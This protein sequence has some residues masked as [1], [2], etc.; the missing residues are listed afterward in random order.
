MK[1]V[2][3][4][5]LPGSGKSTVFD[6]LMQGAG[7]S[8][9]G[10]HGRESV[11]V[12]RVPDPRVDRL[13]AMY[14]PK[15][16]VYTQIQFVDTVATVSGSTKA[17]RG[18]DLFSSVRNCDALA[19]VVANYDPASDPVRDLRAIETE[20]LLADLAVIETRRERIEKEL[21]VGKRQNEREHALVLRCQEALEAER[22]LRGETFDAVEEK[23]LRGFQLLTLKPLLAID[24]Q[25][26]SASGLPAAEGPGRQV[27]SLKALLEREV[28]AL[29]PAE[30]DGFRAELGIAEDGLSIVIRA[31]YRL[32]GLRSFFTVGED[33]VR[34]WTVRGGDKAVDA[35]GEIHSDLAKGFIR[36]E[37]VLWDKLIEA[38][39]EAKARERAWMRLEGR[40]YEVQ[41]GDCL[42][43][44]FNK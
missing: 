34:A 6:I 30:R 26:E 4:L 35:A 20:L 10:A 40:D 43:I 21:R 38:G 9:T 5:G 32:L 11:G 8:A 36:A 25:G 23:T 13:S 44:R 28:L 18:Q 27:V 33:E 2:G 31:C 41:D 39:S 3:L 17:A 12:V 14:N 22:A 42:T 37:V 1:R 16:T 29:P 15:K 19:A 24:N 7:A